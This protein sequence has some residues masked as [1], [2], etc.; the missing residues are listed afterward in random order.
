M[1]ETRTL[2][3]ERIFD[4]PVEKVW[5]AWTEADQIGKWWGPKGFTSDDNKID[6][7]VGGWN[8]LHMHSPTEFGDQDMYSGGE[9]KDIVPLK[10]IVVTDEFTDKDGK[11]VSPG[12]YGMPDDFPQSLLTVDFESLPDGKTKVVIT[13]EGLPAG[14][15]SDQTSAGWN[16]SLD[17]LAESLK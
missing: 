4:A 5:A 9:Y 14:E 6:L 11:K 12:I 16:E 1:A 15:L 10:K 7:R 17:K 8:N 2:T 3:L 13:H